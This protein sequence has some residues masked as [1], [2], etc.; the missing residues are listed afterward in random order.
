MKIMENGICA[1]DYCEAELIVDAALLSNP[2]VRYPQKGETIV[3]TRDLARKLGL[4]VDNP[5]PDEK[6]PPTP[7]A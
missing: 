3:S 1:P 4:I 2:D 6:P 7:P 5:L